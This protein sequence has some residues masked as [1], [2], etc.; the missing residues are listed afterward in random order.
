MTG[1]QAKVIPGWHPVIRRGQGNPVSGCWRES[2]HRCSSR[3][4]L[5]SV[6]K[7]YV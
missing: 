3:L 4:S 2:A 7:V 5:C 6:S 1:F